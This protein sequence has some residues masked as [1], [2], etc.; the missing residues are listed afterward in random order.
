MCHHSP[1]PNIKRDEILT[2]RLQPSSFLFCSREA[3]KRIA[4]FQAAFRGRVMTPSASSGSF[5]LGN[6][7]QVPKGNSSGCHSPGEVGFCLSKYPPAL[8][9][10]V[11]QP[12]N[13]SQTKGA[14]LAPSSQEGLGAPSF[15]SQPLHSCFLP[16]QEMSFN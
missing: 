10:R 6:C 3:L 4:P 16:A 1:F 5:Q 12:D 13:L 15:L 2:F 11:L 8:I 7:P 14:L 9:S